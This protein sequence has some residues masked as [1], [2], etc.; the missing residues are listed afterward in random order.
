MLRMLDIIESTLLSGVSTD[1]W[2]LGL[3]IRKT[4]NF[5]CKGTTILFYFL[6]FVGSEKFSRCD[7]IVLQ[8]LIVYDTFRTS[9]FDASLLAD[10]AFAPII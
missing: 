6:I 5:T 10:D 7:L 2:L 4:E 8:I 3:Y 1:V 9:S